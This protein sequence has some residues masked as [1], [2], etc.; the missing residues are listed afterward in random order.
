VASLWH[1]QWHDHDTLSLYF[2]TFLP[3][4]FHSLFSP[5][6]QV[7]IYH[8]THIDGCCTEWQDESSGCEESSNFCWSTKKS[9]TGL[10]GTST[11]NVSQIVTIMPTLGFSFTELYY[12]VAPITRCQLRIIEC[13]VGIN[14]TRE[15]SP[16]ASSVAKSSKTGTLIRALISPLQTYDLLSI[17]PFA[18]IPHKPYRGRA[19]SLTA[20]I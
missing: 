2:V 20:L 9:W 10:D 6:H 15:H 13:K 16:F 19:R 14:G 5:S 8:I 17:F 1:F 11:R 12:I 7:F 4:L 18:T 3:L